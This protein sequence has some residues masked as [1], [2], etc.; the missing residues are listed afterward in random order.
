M[1][2]SPLAR[3]LAA[4]CLAAV[5]VL[6][7]PSA[8]ARQGRASELLP[9]HALDLGYQVMAFHY[10]ED[11]LME[12]DG[13]MHGVFGRYTAHL[14]ESIM[15][16]AEAEYSGGNLDYDGQYQDGTPAARD[17]WD[18]LFE[19]RGTA[20]WVM[21][22]DAF[23]G[24]AAFIPFAGLAWRY[25]DDVIE[26]AG[27]YEREISQYYAPMG[28]EARCAALDEWRFTARLEYDLFLGG[29]VKSH[30]GDAVAGLGTVTNDQDFGE[31]YGLRASF[32]AE[33]RFDGWSLGVEP[34]WRF[35]DID[36]SE[37]ADLTDQGRV[38]G[39]AWE[40]ANTTRVW[41]LRLFA[42]F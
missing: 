37:N 8:Q 4:A 34:Y 1:P 11:D 6:A 3:A 29:R 24:K 31:G 26:G 17:T 42:G 36:R 27:G 33:R 10:Q 23:H 39:Y 2:F 40:P 13:T 16:R 19:A 5:A 41:G 18:R 30:L 28:L 20:G 9:A 25:W 15:L 32:T 7:A 35:W 22:P 21:A 14:G 38:V 12:E